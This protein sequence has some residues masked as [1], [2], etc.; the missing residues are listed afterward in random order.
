MLLST[1]IYWSFRWFGR[2]FRVPSIVW[3]VSLLNR[4]TSHILCYDGQASCIRLESIFE[5][6]TWRAFM[7]GSCHLAHYRQ[8]FSPFLSSLTTDSNSHLAPVA[9]IDPLD[10]TS[11]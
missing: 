9:A 4:N 3:T 2:R 1:S 6:S 5:I 11:R 8:D 7:Q 10:W